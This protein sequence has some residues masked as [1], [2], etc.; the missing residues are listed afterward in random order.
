MRKSKLGSTGD[1]RNSYEKAQL[2]SDC[3]PTKD[4]LEL[5]GSQIIQI[6]ELGAIEP[7]GTEM[8]GALV[9]RSDVPEAQDN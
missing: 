7:V 1:Q 8:S 2:H 3:I 4:P 6:V 9:S 5:A